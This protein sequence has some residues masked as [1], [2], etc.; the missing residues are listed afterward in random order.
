MPEKSKSLII[1][2]CDHGGAYDYDKGKYLTFV[3]NYLEERFGE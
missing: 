2:G 1:G 3:F